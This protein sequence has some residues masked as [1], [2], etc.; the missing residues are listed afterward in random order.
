MDCVCLSFLYRFPYVFAHIPSLLWICVNSSF[1]P[2]KQSL[3]PSILAID[4]TSPS[5]QSPLLSFFPSH[6]SFYS[7][8]PQLPSPTLFII[9]CLLVCVL[10]LHSLPSF[11]S[12]FL[13]FFL[14]LFTYFHQQKHVT[15]FILA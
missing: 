2:S 4:R 14:H 3:F 5:F 15:R 7:L 8:F 1:F 9:F 13:L 6:F 11:L 10:Y 12:L